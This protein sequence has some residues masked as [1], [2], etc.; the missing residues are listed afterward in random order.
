MTSDSFSDG[1]EFLDEG[2]AEEKGKE[3]MQTGAFVIDI[4]AQSS[5]VN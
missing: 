4:S 2:K 1:G 3:L 5:N